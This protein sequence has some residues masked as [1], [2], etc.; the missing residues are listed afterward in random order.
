MRACPILA[1]PV[2]AYLVLPHTQYL[3][4]S[5]F[6]LTLQ[7]LH[8]YYAA[9]S[10]LLCSCFILTMQLLEFLLIRMRVGPRVALALAMK[11]TNSELTP[12]AHHSQIRK[13]ESAGVRVVMCGEHHWRCEVSYIFPLDGRCALPARCPFLTAPRMLQMLWVLLAPRLLSLPLSHACRFLVPA[14]HST[15][16]HHSSSALPHPTH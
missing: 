5:C 1:M 10:Y 9:A 13:L 14:T 7:L 11:L 16:A 6:I 2:S 8:T 12:G 15:A 3:L 4:C